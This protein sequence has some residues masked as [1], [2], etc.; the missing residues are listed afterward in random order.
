M[1]MIVVCDA[2]RLEHLPERLP[3]PQQLDAAARQRKLPV[4]ERRCV[5]PRSRSATSR[6]YGI[7]VFGSRWMKSKMPCSPGSRP[8]MNVD[9]ATGLCGGIDVPSGAKPPRRGQPREM[10]QPALRRSVARQLVVEAVEAEDDDAPAGRRRVPPQRE[11]PRRATQRRSDERQRA[12]A[13]ARSCDATANGRPSMCAGGSMPNSRSAVGAMSTSAGSCVVDRA[14][15][16]EHAGHQPRVDAVVAAPRLDVVLE[17]RPRRRR[18][19]RSPTTCGS[20]RCSR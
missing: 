19:W 20:R 12:R 13:A 2:A 17:H 15:A 1:R 16:E 4:A 14:V 8:V 11:Q 6:G 7:I 5:R 3:V 9:Q 10:R 18:R